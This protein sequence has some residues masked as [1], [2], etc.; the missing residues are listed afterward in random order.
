MVR[1]DPSGAEVVINRRV[2]GTTPLVLPSADPDTVMEIRKRGFSTVS[3][4][5]RAAES[6]VLQVKLDPITDEQGEMFAGAVEE[7]SKTL[8]LVL[9]GASSILAGGFSAYFKVKADEVHRE[10]LLTGDPSKLAETRKL[11]N[12]SALA[13]GASQVFFG[14]FS[15]LMLT[16]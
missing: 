13:L 14:L 16:P 7:Q 8:P 3:L 10:Y 4:N 11:D 9:S 12:V 2:A 15:Y 5:S 1:S 6:G